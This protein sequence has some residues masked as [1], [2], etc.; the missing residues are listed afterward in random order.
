MNIIRT[1]LA[2]ACTA[3]LLVA[4]GDNPQDAPEAPP[5][6]TGQVPASAT[7]S[8]RA[9]A[10]F[11]ASLPASESGAPLSVDGVTPPTSE[12]EAPLTL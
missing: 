6:T 1:T 11:A 10:Q 8:P 5:T 2:A 7:A 9:Y 12:T 3:T 4:C